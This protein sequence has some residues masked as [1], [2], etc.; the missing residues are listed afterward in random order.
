LVKNVCTGFKRGT[1]NRLQSVSNEDISVPR[2]ANAGQHKGQALP[3]QPMA[4]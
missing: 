3:S 1:Y 2:L 4:R